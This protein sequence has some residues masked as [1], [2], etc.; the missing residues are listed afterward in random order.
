[1]N[2]ISVDLTSDSYQIH[3]GHHLL[4]QAGNLIRSHTSGSKILLVTHPDMNKL[5]GSELLTSLE[6]AG[7]SVT[8]ATV[9]TG[10]HAKSFESYRKLV[11]VLAENRFTREDIVVALGG[12]VIGDLAGFVAATYMR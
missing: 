1:M 3:V 10:E 7:Y 11:S 4:V 5:Y 6:S 2:T 12:G 9:S 8:T